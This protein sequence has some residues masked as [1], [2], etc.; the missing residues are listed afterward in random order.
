MDTI[1][2][3]DYFLTDQDLEKAQAFFKFMLNLKHHHYIEQI[4]MALSNYSKIRIDG[5]EITKAELFARIEQFEQTQAHFIAGNLDFD[6][7][8]K[9]AMTTC[10]PNSNNFAYMSY[11]L[12]G[13]VGELAGKIAKGIRKGL[14]RL[15]GNE[16]TL[17]RDDEETN[18]EA[19]DLIAGVIDEAGDCLWELSGLLTTL[20]CSLGGVAK[21]NLKKLADRKKRGVIVGNGDNR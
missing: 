17:N 10:V 21:N 18:Q 12:V 11:G 8:Q 7:Y 15:R 2:E 19:R 4:P 6:T 20:G 14:F 1:N 5:R 16:I 9:Q 3:K 13:E